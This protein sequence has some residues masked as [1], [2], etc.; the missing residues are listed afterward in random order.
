[1][2]FLFNVFALIALSLAALFFAGPYYLFP[3]PN[4]E[5][6]Q[7][8][9]V[10]AATDIDQYVKQT[11]APMLEDI[12]A[13]QQKTIAWYNTGTHDRTEIAIVYIH[14]WS[15]SSKDT[16]PLM[17][18]L[19]SRLHA[20]VYYA[21][22]NAHGMKRP[23]NFEKLKMQDLIDDAR[24]AVEIGKRIGKHVLLVGISTGATLAV[25]Q[26]YEKRTSTEPSAVVLLSPNFMPLKKEARFL[27]G[28][29]GRLIARATF[30]T[31]YSYPSLNAQHAEYWTTSYPS[32]GLVPLMDLVN[33]TNSLD[34]SLVH[35][36]VLLLYTHFDEVVNVSTMHRKFEQ[37]GEK[38]PGVVKDM[39][40]LEGATQHQLVGDLFGPKATGNAADAIS[41]FAKSVILK[42]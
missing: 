8:A 30:G 7:V 39:I 40:D 11:E 1:M 34:L 10:Q 13:G 32:D 9:Q 28:P 6:P 21:R 25:E 33:Y 27:T 38:E 18:F 31:T 4:P 41:E 37:W 24:E 3:T 5:S 14:G 15:A 12:K 42:R 29:F 20:N 35:A 36:P 16:A 2:K 22:L 19:S 26:A 23:D 17:S